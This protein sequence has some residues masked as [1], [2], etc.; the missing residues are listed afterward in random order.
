MNR[1]ANIRDLDNSSECELF[2]YAM[3]EREVTERYRKR[4][5]CLFR[6]PSARSK[7]PLGKLLEEQS[8]NEAMLVNQSSS[9]TLSSVGDADIGIEC[10]KEVE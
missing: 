8:K 3:A 6:P 10:R 9:S 1:L 5:L 7:N 4:T 2:K